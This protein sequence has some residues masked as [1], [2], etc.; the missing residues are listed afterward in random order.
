MFDSRKIDAFFNGDKPFDNVKADNKPQTSLWLRFVK[1]GFPCV[2]A[3]LL[4]LMV[5]MPNIKKSVILQDNVTL[6]RKNEMEKL[7]IEKTI[8]NFTDNKNRV[9]TI[10]ADNVDE[11]AAG[12]PEVK[13]N[14]PHGEIPGDNGVIRISADVGFF[15][16][17]S[18][19]LRLSENM[20]TYDENGT[21]IKTDEAFYDFKAE[22]GWGIK[23]IYAE[24]NWGKVTAAG[25]EYFKKDNILVLTGNHT[26]VTKD[27]IMSA[28]KETRFFQTENKAVSRG[29]AQIKQGKNTLKADKIVSRLKQGN[30]QELQKL[31]A[32]GNV[33]IDTP[34]GKAWGDRGVYNPDSSQIELFDNVRLE[35]NG[36][37]INGSYA[38]TDL[39]TSVSRIVADKQKGE[40]I[41]GTFYNKRKTK[42]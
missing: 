16:Q 32:F 36:N 11:I 26:I 2:A 15:N 5:V 39:N 8:Y 29:K 31:E 14:N 23:D 35:Q 33:I 27:G 24:G 3:A 34:K 38:K 30:K 40:R 17:E 41:T 13:I 37:V 4:G 6:P 25:F 21:I 19:V 22:R 20:R 9:S 28:E 1:L 7:H 10:V 18:S 12:N 42:K